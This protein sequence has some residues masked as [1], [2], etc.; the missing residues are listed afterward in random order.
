ML[1]GQ[2]KRGMDWNAARESARARMVA[3]QAAMATAGAVVD[4]EEEYEE[5]E[6]YEEEEEEEGSFTGFTLSA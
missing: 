1:T 2:P 3:A 5:V 6:E 4:E